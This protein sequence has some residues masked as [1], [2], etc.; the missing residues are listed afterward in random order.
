MSVNLQV[1]AAGLTAVLRERAEGYRRSA[2][3][4]E[5]EVAR[6][7]RLAGLFEEIAN[8]IAAGALN[9]EQA[10]A[11]FGSAIG[12]DQSVADMIA[13]KENEEARLRRIFGIPGD[14]A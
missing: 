7:R 12:R 5:Q 1:I 3:Y 2:Q 6:N 9:V 4:Y 13:G 11:A 14:A 8:R 10:E